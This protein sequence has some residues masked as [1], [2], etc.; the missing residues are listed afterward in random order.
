MRCE[1]DHK[2]FFW[3]PRHKGTD[4]QH[5]CST[6]ITPEQVIDMIKRIPKFLP[7]ESD[8]SI[9]DIVITAWR[10]R[11]SPPCNWI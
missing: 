5:I 7:K 2:D 3:C 6:T 9:I 8:E 10:R 11:K 4:Q 1:F